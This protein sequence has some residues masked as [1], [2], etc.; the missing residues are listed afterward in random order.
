MIDW[1]NTPQSAPTDPKGDDYE[2]MPVQ[3]L[4][5]PNRAELKEVVG[6]WKRKRADRKAQNAAT[7]PDRRLMLTRSEEAHDLFSEAVLFCQP[8]P[9]LFAVY[10]VSGAGDTVIASNG[11][12]SW[13]AAPCPPC[14]LPILRSVVV[15][16]LGTAV[17][18]LPNWSRIVRGN[19]AVLS[20]D[21]IN[22]TI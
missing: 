2:N 5:T 4:I 6:S 11:L 18:R 10:D 3:L 19:H 14:T 15:A 21:K 20:I 13:Q 12:A 1:A 22:R 9:C 7:R 16:K 17:V 8:Y